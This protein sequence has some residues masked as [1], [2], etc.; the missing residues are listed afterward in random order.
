MTVI[1]RLVAG[2]LT[3]GVILVAAAAAWYADDNFHVVVPGQLYRAAQFNAKQLEDAVKRHGIRSVINLRGA[4][5]EKEWYQTSRDTGALL[6]LQ[7]YDVNLGSRQLPA[8]TEFLKLIEALSRAP[9]PVLV[10]CQSGADRSGL[11]SAVG[12]LLDGNYGLADAWRQTGLRYRVIH[13]DTAGKQV[14]QRY[15]AWLKEK[16]VAHNPERFLSWVGNDYVDSRGNLWFFVDSIND[17]RLKEKDN[18]M[19]INGNVFS[20]SGWAFDLRHRTLIRNVTVMLDDRALPETRYALARND[21][22]EHF[23]I[24]GVA[25]SGWNVQTDVSGWAKRCYNFGLRLTRRDNS[26]W[27]S[28]PLAEVCLN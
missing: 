26:V 17:T 5:K 24:P 19:K 2:C 22:A 21:V 6:G 13:S 11:A 18:V 20:S 27:Q 12:L 14:L 4:N 9:R 15:E 23:G 16:G 25:A 1:K 28:A 10:H 7:F 3:A 8:V